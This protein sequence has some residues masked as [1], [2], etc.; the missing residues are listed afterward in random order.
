MLVANGGVP[1]PG[2][3]TGGTSSICWIDELAL[4]LA[5]V[6]HLIDIIVSDKP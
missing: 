4:A 1:C 3:A 2:E 6:V 5:V